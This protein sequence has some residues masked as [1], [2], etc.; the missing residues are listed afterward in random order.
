M[1]RPYASAMASPSPDAT[2]FY[3]RAS[4]AEPKPPAYA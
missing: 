2:N 1:A 4:K 3:V